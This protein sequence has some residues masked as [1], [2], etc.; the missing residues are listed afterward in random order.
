[1]QDEAATSEASGPAPPAAGWRLRVGISCFV[2]GLVCP[3]FVPLVT[4][5]SLTAEWKTAASGLLLLGV[6]ELLWIVAAA[7][8][9]KAGFEALKTRLLAVF[10]RVALPSRVSRRRHRVGL[11]LFVLPLLFGW[12]AP[13]GSGLVPGYEAHRLAW[14]LGGDLMLLTSLFV[15]GGEFWEKLGALFAY[16]GKRLE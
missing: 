13:Y 10:K 11:V 9:G 1:M 16:P 12:L 8:L 3:V 15:L 4:A 6:P 7:V 2:L 14:N 5:S